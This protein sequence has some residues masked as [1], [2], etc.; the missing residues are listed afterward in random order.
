[1]GKILFTSAIVVMTLVLAADALSLDRMIS[2][3][4]GVASGPDVKLTTD[5]V[6]K[7]GLGDNLPVAGCDCTYSTHMCTPTRFVSLCAH[8]SKLP[9]PNV[10]HSR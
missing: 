5:T 9:I 2:L 3:R 10:V 7:E 8:T 6:A 4:G 1:M